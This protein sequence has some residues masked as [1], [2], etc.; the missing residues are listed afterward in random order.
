MIENK[1]GVVIPTRGDRNIFL[2]KCLSMMDEQTLKPDVYCIVD[3]HPKSNEK[4]ITFRYKKGFKELF[5]QGCEVVFLIEDDDFYCENYIK[6]MFSKWME[7]NK[8][9][10]LGIGNTIY[11]HLQRKQYT[12]MIHPTRSSAFST[13]VTNA[14]LNIK[15]PEDNYPFLDLELWKQL[16]G[17]TF[18]PSVPICLGMKHGVGIC[19][20]SGHNQNFNYKNEDS[21]SSYLKKITGNGF[22][23]Y[24]KIF[25]PI[26]LN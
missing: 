26:G 20:G 23:Y 10:I 8:P 16:N 7:L 22:K 2:K 19:G 5:E 21:D 14:V 13:M 3:E 11:Y 6:T 9:E 25:H 1:I 17:K 4:D 24:K 18:I 12:E 15:W